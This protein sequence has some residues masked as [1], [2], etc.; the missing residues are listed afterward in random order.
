MNVDGHK[1]KVA[2]LENSLNEL[3]PDPEGKHVVAVVEL[4]YGILLHMIAIGM[5]T[6]HGMHSDTHVGLPRELRNVGET[7]IA[8]IFGMLDSFRAGKWYGS[9]GNGQ[10][11]RKC[12]EFIEKVKK[13]ALS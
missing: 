13:W 2:E 7:N 11:V 6:K 3:L 12:L 1:K 4:T 10:V 8:E 5:E 9:K